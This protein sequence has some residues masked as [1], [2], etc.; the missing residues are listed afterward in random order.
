MAFQELAVAFTTLCC[1]GASISNGYWIS[2]YSWII[3]VPELGIIIICT[4]EIKSISSYIP[5]AK[6][7]TVAFSWWYLSWIFQG[8]VGEFKLGDSHFER[9]RNAN[10]SCWRELIVPVLV[11]NATFPPPG[12]VNWMH[13]TF[14]IDKAWC[15]SLQIVIRRRYISST[16]ESK[17]VVLHDL[18]S[19]ASVGVSSRTSKGSDGSLFAVNYSVTIEITSS[20]NFISIVALSMRSASVELRLL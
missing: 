4:V 6:E 8:F 19:M 5:R 15:W 9:S 16:L 10:T 11:F 13:V 20:D 3:D 18:S 2:L 12:V 14:S 17:L 7:L 1:I